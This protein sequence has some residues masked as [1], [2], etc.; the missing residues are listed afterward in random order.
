MCQKLFFFYILLSLVILVSKSSH[1]CTAAVV[2]VNVET[3]YQASAS[4]P[5]FNP[6]VVVASFV[7]DCPSLQVYGIQF[8][9]D[10]ANGNSTFS[11]NFTLSMP[12]AFSDVVG[13]FAGSINSGNISLPTPTATICSNVTENTIVHAAGSFSLFSFGF[14]S[15]STL[16]R[17]SATV[18]YTD[19]LMIESNSAIEIVLPIRLAASAFAA[20]S[21]G[22]SGQT[23]GIVTASFSGSVN[24]TPLSG[25]SLSIESLSVIPEQDSIELSA[26]VPLSLSA[27]VNVFE[28]SIEG[29]F[30]VIAN[31]TP[32]GLF[33]L[34]SGSATAG[35]T[36][37]GSF[38]IDFFRAADGSSLPEG[39]RIVSEITGYV[40][41]EAAL[42]PGDF[43]SDGDVDGADFLKWQRYFG[44]TS[45]LDADG[46]GNGIIDAADY[47]IWQDNF[48]TGQ[49][50]SAASVPEPSSCTLAA[51]TISA[52]F[53]SRFA[54]C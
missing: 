53:I 11:S 2:E 40:Y 34:L 24:S 38:E 9:T 36:L 21:F 37:P 15:V 6:A 27:G 7:S 31:A 50:V 29:E 17:G 32:A 26:E 41:T 52:L 44:S 12:D 3:T 28:V 48:G 39:I 43:D 30:E 14:G 4:A 42:S 5:I 47:T 22:A 45:E 8:S 51:L 19:T 16:Q 35:L 54:G 13:M 18:S 46:N 1:V 33:N 49:P 25:G 20:E 10:E 23:E